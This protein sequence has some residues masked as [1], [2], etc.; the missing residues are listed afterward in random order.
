[1]K[2]TIARFRDV[3][4]ARMNLLEEEARL[5]EAEMRE[6][7]GDY[8]HLT[9]ENIAMLDRHIAHVE[10]LKLEFQAMDL[11]QFA[12]ADGFTHHVLTRLQELYDARPFLRP[13]VRMVM[14]CVND[15]HK[16]MHDQ[17]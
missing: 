12:N 9:L 14:A 16:I 1:M 5:S 8:R 6:K 7:K 10:K 3:L 13:A 4:V 15:M 2:E 17:P 11:D